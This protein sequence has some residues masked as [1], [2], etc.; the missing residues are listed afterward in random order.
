MIHRKKGGMASSKMFLEF[1]ENF[2]KTEKQFV[3]KDST[4]EKLVIYRQAFDYFIQEFKTYSAVLSE[5]KNGYEMSILELEESKRLL[6][7]LKGKLAILK[8]QNLQELNKQSNDLDE[9]LEKFRIE[10]QNLREESLTLTEK[11]QVQKQEISS[12]VQENLVLK[13]KNEIKVKV[14]TSKVDGLSIKEIQQ[15]DLEIAKLQEQVTNANMK[16]SDLSRD[17]QG[18]MEN[19]DDLIT[20][21]KLYAEMKKTEDLNRKNLEI[22]EEITLLNTK[23]EDLHKENED[24]AKKTVLLESF[25]FPDWQYIQYQVPY[26]IREYEVSCKKLNCNDVIVMILLEI[27]KVLLYLMTIR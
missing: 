10:N 16:I 14:E 27:L 26:S 7:P 18:L 9:F 13:E 15:K 6:E 1:L 20:P 4:L 25:K 12:L 3:R 5:I 8:L 23:I 17:L 2:I 24:N 19:N 21:D 11:I 22:Q